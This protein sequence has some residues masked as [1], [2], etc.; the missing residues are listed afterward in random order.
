MAF[1]SWSRGSVTSWG[2]TTERNAAVN[3]HAHSL[4][5]VWLGGDVGYSPHPR[6]PLARAR[7]AAQ[8]LGLRLVR[9]DDHDHLQ[10]L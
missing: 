2:R 5:M 9:E 3:G 8:Q 1:C 7:K 6:P 4:H 10:S